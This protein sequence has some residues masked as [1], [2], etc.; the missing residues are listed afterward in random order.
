MK[1]I[2]K[3]IKKFKRKQRKYASKIKK[4]NKALQYNLRAI[5]EPGYF[6]YKYGTGAPFGH[7][8]D[9]PERDWPQRSQHIFYRAAPITGDQ[10]GEWVAPSNENYVL[11]YSQTYV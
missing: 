2:R 11:R 9:D 6:P 7:F 10:M 8:D 3:L 1:E 4:G 5:K